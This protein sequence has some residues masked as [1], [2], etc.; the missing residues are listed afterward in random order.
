[1]YP[2]LRYTPTW[3]FYFEIFFWKFEIIEVEKGK[4]GEGRRLWRAVATFYGMF[5]TG[6]RVF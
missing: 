3:V 6:K 5:L 1:M 4:R 2:T